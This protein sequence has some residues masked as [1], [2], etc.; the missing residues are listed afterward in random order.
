[1]KEST[2]RRDVLSVV[3][4]AAQHTTLPYR[5]PELFEGGIRTG[6]TLD[7][8]AVDVWSL[9]CT[10][11][12][13]LYGAS[14][15]ECDFAVTSGG[16]CTIRIVDCTHLSVLGSVPIPR[17]AIADW[18]KRTDWRTLLLEPMLSPDPALR[19][20]LPEVIAV[21]ERLIQ[22]L[23]GTVDRE[24]MASTDDD[25]DEELENEDGISLM[26]KVV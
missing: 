5:P 26:S 20:T 3:D 9:A 17:G 8:R 24:S 21:T 7:Y 22:Q 18:Y 12:A 10:L 4:E 19:P 2:T 14:P 16:A 11:H 23:G 1:M 13:L 15:F 6:T 25:D